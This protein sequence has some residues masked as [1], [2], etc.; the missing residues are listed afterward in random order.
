MKISSLIITALCAISKINAGSA[1]VEFSTSD[2]SDDIELESFD[3]KLRAILPAGPGP[4]LGYGLGG[5]E[6]IAYDSDSNI[7]Y[8]LSEQGFVNV[9]KFTG[10]AFEDLELS[11]DFDGAKLTDVEVCGDY[12]FVSQSLDTSP[13]K[14]N[15]YDAL[16]TGEEDDV[17]L[18]SSTIVGVVPDMIKPNPDCTVLAVANE[19]EGDYDG[20]LILP[21][22]SVSLL[23]DFASATP[24]VT[25]V[26]L[27]K[28]TDDELLAKGVHMPLTLNAMEYWDDNSDIADDIDFSTARSGYSSDMNLEP[29]YVVWSADGSKLVVNLQENSAAVLIDVPMPT[30]PE[31]L[32]IVA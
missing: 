9:F 14:V 17:T 16:K 8:G 30:A 2:I 6:Q 18:I 4:L 23:T 15:I 31:V 13:G 5:L 3:F 25:T 27:D 21:V 28:W 11:I 7:L 1:V 24:V 29:E 20:E 22:G 32:D 19:G 10:E 12:L 26:A